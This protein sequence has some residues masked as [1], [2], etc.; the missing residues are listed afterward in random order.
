MSSFPTTASRFAAWLQMTKPVQV[1]GT[2]EIKNAAQRAGTYCINKMLAGKGPEQVIQ[3]GQM[4]TDIVKLSNAGTGRFVEPGRKRSL[5][6][7]HT[8]RRTNAQW[9]FCEANRPFTEAEVILNGGDEKAHWKK[10]RKQFQRDAKSDMLETMESSLV[11]LPSDIMETGA[12]LTDSPPMSLP[13]FI[14]ENGVLPPST[15]W[16]G[17]TIQGIDPTVE[18]NWRNKVSQY[19]PADPFNITTGIL[20]AFDVLFPQLRYA[21]PVKGGDAY[22]PDNEAQVFCVT[23]LDGQVMFKQACAARNDTYNSKDTAE[24]AYRGAEI[25]YL[26]S[27]DTAPLDVTGVVINGTAAADRGTWNNVAWPAGFPRYWAINRAELTPIVHPE[28]FMAE[29]TVSGAMDQHD[30]MAMIFESWY[31]IWCSMR[32]RHGLVRPNV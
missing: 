11:A 12:A 20:G 26:E 5:T 18:R 4:I 27:L 14:A 15:L 6:A 29:K 23:N 16:T 3:S 2:D 8:T 17:T 25:H 19:D 24:P 30:T 21:P 1:T 22:T 13:V 32:N 7:S 31:N 10:L 28:K 9:R